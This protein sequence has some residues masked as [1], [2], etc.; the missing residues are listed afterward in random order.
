MN[1]ARFHSV[2]LVIA[3][4]VAATAACSTTASDSG[5][6]GKIEPPAGQV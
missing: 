2:H 4:A 1:V 5:Y 3:L 6:F